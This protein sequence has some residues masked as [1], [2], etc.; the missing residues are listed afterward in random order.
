MIKIYRKN[1]RIGQYK[2]I[3]PLLVPTKHEKKTAM[4]L[5]IE[6]KKAERALIL[7]KETGGIS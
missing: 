6:I 1:E 3:S 4:H 7:L 5:A 2:E